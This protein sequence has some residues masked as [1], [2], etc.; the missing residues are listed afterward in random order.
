MGCKDVPSVFP[1]LLNY[2]RALRF[3]DRPDYADLRRICKDLLLREGFA[4]DGVFDWTKLAA[5]KNAS[6]SSNQLSVDVGAEVGNSSANPATGNEK[7]GGAAVK[8]QSPAQAGVAAQSG[9]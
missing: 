7:E 3:L 1:S 5:E 6:R 2:A 4:N 8:D 9:N